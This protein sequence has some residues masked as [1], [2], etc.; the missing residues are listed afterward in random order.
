[1]KNV[2]LHRNRADSKTL[3][4]LLLKIGHFVEFHS[5]DRAL[6][7]RE[8]RYGNCIVIKNNER[9]TLPVFL[10][11]LIPLGEI[12]LPVSGAVILLSKK[13]V[14]SIF[15]YLGQ[16]VKF[17]KCIASYLASIRVNGIKGERGSFETDR[18]NLSSIL[19]NA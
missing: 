13:G 3:L 8:K 19:R 5:G 9:F 2:G 11:L 6:S 10:T 14:Y 17:Q 16:F 7:I 15:L 1:M 12:I 18:F 4:L